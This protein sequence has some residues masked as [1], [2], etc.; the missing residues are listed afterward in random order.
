MIYFIKLFLKCLIDFNVVVYL[1]DCIVFDF[2][3]V[4]FIIGY[5]RVKI[6]FD[7]F[8]MDLNKL[9]LIDKIEKGVYDILNI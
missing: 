7:G 6:K 1:E 5:F 4:N 9:Y 2:C 8:F 3:F